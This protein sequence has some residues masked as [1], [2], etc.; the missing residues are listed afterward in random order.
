MLTVPVLRS[1]HRISEVEPHVLPAPDLTRDKHEPGPCSG[2]QEASLVESRTVKAGRAPAP[3]SSRTRVLSG[4]D[5]CQPGCED[6]VAVNTDAV[7]IEQKLVALAVLKANF[8]HGGHGYIDSFVPFAMEA[9]ALSGA[10]TIRVDEL[11]RATGDL[12][13][14]PIPEAA[15]R[16]V[17]SRAAARGLGEPLR[18]YEWSFDPQKVGRFDSTQLRAD[19]AREQR[20]LMAEL[21]EFAHTEHG[22]EL[23]QEDAER[24]LIHHISA[25][26]SEILLQATG[27]E[28]DARTRRDADF[29]TVSFI[30][31]VLDREPDHAKYLERLVIGSMIAAS[32]RGGGPLDAVTDPF[33]DLT[34]FL[35]TPILLDLLKRPGDV[36]RAAA[37]E[38]VK[39]LNRAGARIAVFDHTLAEVQAIYHGLSESLKH[40]FG[41]GRPAA[42]GTLEEYA[43]T[44]KLQASDLLSMAS[45]AESNL[46]RIGVAVVTPPVRTESNV[47]IDE[48]E[49]EELI[50]A[51]V[52]AENSNAKVATRY[53]TDSITGVER[54]RGGR[55]TKLE[56]CTAIFVVRNRSLIRATRR[57]YPYEVVGTPVAIH[58]NDIVTLAWLKCPAEVPDLPRLRLAADA[59]AATRPSRVLMDRYTDVLVDLRSK[60]EISEKDLYE[61]RYATE[62][63]AILMQRTRGDESRLDEPTVI[64]MIEDTRRSVQTTIEASVA[65]EAAQLREELAREIQ[66]RTD[67]EKAAE[68]HAADA[69]KHAADARAARQ[70]VRYLRWA[71]AAAILVLDGVGGW[72]LWGWLAGTLRHAI[73]AVALLMVFAA[74]VATV[75]SRRRA[76]SILGGVAVGLGL[77]EATHN[78]MSSG[79]DHRQPPAAPSKQH[80]K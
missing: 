57:I 60:D 20:A 50:A 33:E 23:S 59:F 51:E 14:F 52:H 69:E 46:G 31:R 65:I 78:L 37:M 27:R 4:V 56:N 70:T 61:M 48:A 32:L 2:N 18:G 19:L 15:L 43:L 26:G 41:R 38:S 30:S 63:H 80:K 36:T 49:A 22:V 66:S 25:A 11:Q 10:S 8:D 13:G 76:A 28:A 53:D 54:I 7:A 29:V 17:V 3:R 58:V 40:G 35:D 67:A 68:K 74:A 21:Q 6:G 39:L 9:A 1:T 44:H 73:L 77:L 75:S 79:D 34:V 42:F 12:L 45:S 72:L 64:D 24:A 16:L 47:R 55:K 62:A 5:R 71:V